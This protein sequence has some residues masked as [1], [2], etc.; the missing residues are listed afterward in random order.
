MTSENEELGTQFRFVNEFTA[1]VNSVGTD[2]VIQNCRMTLT[3]RLSP[4]AG[5]DI[6]RQVGIDPAD[7]VL[8][9]YLKGQEY[10][11]TTGPSR[12]EKTASGHCVFF[13]FRTADHGE[14]ESQ[15]ELTIRTGA[16]MYYK[17]AGMTSYASSTFADLTP[18]S[19]NPTQLGR[20]SSTRTGHTSENIL[21]YP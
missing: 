4:S 13:V 17:K 14:L 5:V 12:G 15:T 11:I 1:T 2:T 20:T 8:A 7:D 10:E 3:P 6:R 16:T 19:Q 21:L 18:V 9:L